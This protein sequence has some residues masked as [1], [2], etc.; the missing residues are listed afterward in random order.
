MNVKPEISPLLPQR[1]RGASDEEA[2]EYR[3]GAPYDSPL[4]RAKSMGPPDLAT[5]LRSRIL[6]Q[7]K[8]VRTPIFCTV[9]PNQYLTGLWP[10]LILVGIISWG[11]GH[12]KDEDEGHA[13]VFDKGC[14]HMCMPLYLALAARDPKP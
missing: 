14:I 2:L 1:M 3:L 13:F 8:M 5:L 9:D 4:I 12:A 10:S 11:L 6:N 7:Q